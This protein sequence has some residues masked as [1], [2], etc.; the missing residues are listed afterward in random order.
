ADVTEADVASQLNG[1]TPDFA[2]ALSNPALGSGVS[3]TGGKFEI[4]LLQSPAKVFKLL[5]G[6]DVDLFRWD[7]PQLD[8]NLSINQEFP[9]LGPID[10]SFGGTLHIHAQAGFGYDTFGL[11]QW[12]KTGDP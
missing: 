11:R 4:P 1:A 5:L 6:Q 8:L 7:M 12:K 10:V 9:V 3:T 2:S